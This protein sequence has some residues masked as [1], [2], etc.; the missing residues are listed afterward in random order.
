L[1]KASGNDYLKIK[2]IVN[3]PVA[4]FLYFI[5]FQVEYNEVEDERIRKA[6]QK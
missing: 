5:N 4:E 1:Y 3:T 2:E 6:H